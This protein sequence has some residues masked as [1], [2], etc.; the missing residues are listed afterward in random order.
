MGKEDIRGETRVLDW[1]AHED[2]GVTLIP[3]EHRERRGGGEW[4]SET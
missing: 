4:E 2:A 3:G 1:G